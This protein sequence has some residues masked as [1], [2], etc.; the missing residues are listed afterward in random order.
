[1]VRIAKVDDTGGSDRGTITVGGGGGVSVMI[2]RWIDPYCCC[3]F[4]NCELF[5]RGIGATRNPALAGDGGGD[6]GGGD[7]GRT[8]DSV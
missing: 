1:M 8:I 5:H 3:R 7:G 6:G 2:R 4:P